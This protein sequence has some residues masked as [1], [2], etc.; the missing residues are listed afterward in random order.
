MRV[1]IFLRSFFSIY[2]DAYISISSKR[3]IWIISSAF[4]RILIL[5]AIN[6]LL[7]KQ[8]DFQN[9]SSYYIVL[10]IYN[11]FGSI[12]I[13]PF[14]DYINKIFFKTSNKY[15][16]SFFL[17]SY[18]KKLFLPIAFV[19]LVLLVIALYF[20]FGLSNNYFI[21]I[22]ILISL[23]LIFRGVFD[24]NISFINA[25]GYYKWY[26]ILI[27]FN[28]IIYYSLSYLFT[29][30][31]QPTYFYW[32]GGFVLS[33]IIV[34]TITIYVLRTNTSNKTPKLK[35]SFN[36]EVLKFLPSLITTNL[37]LWF[38]T[39]G[40]RFFSEFK[41]GL[42]ESAILLL[43]FALASQI[44]SITTNFI[45]PIFT[46]N[47]LKGYSEESKI[48]RYLSLK[49]YLLKIVPFLF[50]S[51]VLAL[52]FSKTIINILVHK[53]KIKEDL[54]FIFIIGLFVEFIRSLV[55]VIKNY[56]LSEN[57]LIYQ[58]YSLVIPS[59]LLLLTPFIAISSTIVFALYIL[60][61]YLIY[62]FISFLFSLRL[63]NKSD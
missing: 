30:F 18:Y 20:Y 57:K 44:F 12:I 34:S 1:K 33:N 35:F 10:S 36:S 60:L 46:P 7:T 42:D 15:D 29:E 32:I 38:L 21:E 61:I 24:A 37:L 11:F 3:S 25:L 13:G 50:L 23:M 27:I 53:S 59:I 2:R 40:F 62:L 4:L 31:L 17:E 22:P 47:L 45:L 6:K 19:S 54:I 41:F 9:L 39:D 5:I 55:S 56:K 63:K 48:N 43:G 52:I 51:L 58:V 14:G 16:I 49:N 26:S 28:A 8:L